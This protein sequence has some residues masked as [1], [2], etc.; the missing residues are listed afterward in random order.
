M[1]EEASVRNPITA[2]ERWQPSYPIGKPGIG[3]D[4]HQAN[5]PAFDAWM[6]AQCSQVCRASTAS[7]R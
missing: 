5:Q 2:T 4:P 1:C 7:G 6:S 3:S